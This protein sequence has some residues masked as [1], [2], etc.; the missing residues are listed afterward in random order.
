MHDRGYKN[1]H[2]M[3][4]VGQAVSGR[5]AKTHS[6]ASEDF[7]RALEDS[8]SHANALK[9]ISNGSYLRI[10]SRAIA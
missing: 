9:G 8:V 2:G 7:Q 10:V 1:F 3:T 4:V 6:S 5:A